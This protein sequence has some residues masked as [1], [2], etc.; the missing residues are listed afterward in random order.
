MGLHAGKAHTL[1]S[2]NR[3]SSWLFASVQIFISIFKL[4]DWMTYSLTEDPLGCSSNQQP[5]H[6]AEEVRMLLRP[7]YRSSQRCAST[8]LM[9]RLLVH[10]T[11]QC[12]I[13]D[14]RDLIFNRNFFHLP[15][16]KDSEIYP[17]SPDGLK[18]ECG[19][20]SVNES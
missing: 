19:T 6:T 8:S 18:M 17:S 3:A 15:F 16:T 7:S 20:Y 9:L 2:H 4:S 12:I 10:F 5:Q 14:H 11:Q 1:H 13:S